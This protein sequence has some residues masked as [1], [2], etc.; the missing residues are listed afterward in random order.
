[1]PDDI[2]SILDNIRKMAPENGRIVFVSGDFNIIHP[3]HQ[4]I[5]NFAASCGDFLVVGINGDN[6]NKKIVPEEL[7]RE[8]IAALSVVNY[9]FILQTSPED[10]IARLKPSVVVKG[11]E[12]R[13]SSNVEQAVVE[14]YG[15]KLLF[16]SGSSVFSSV[17]L[18]RDEFSGHDFSSIHKPADFPQR[19]GFSIGE[20]GDI[21]SRFS[22]LNVVVV[23]D[24]IVDEYIDC[25]TLGMSREDPTLVVT[26][27]LSKQFVGG[28]GIVA[29]H[30]RKLGAKTTYFGI[31]GKDRTARYAKE[32]LQAYDVD[33]HLLADETRPTTLKQRYRAANKTLLRVSHLRQHDIGIDLIT[34]LGERIERALATADLLIFSDFNYGCLPQ[35]LVDRIVELCRK[36]GIPIAADSQ[37]SSQLG[38][39]SRFRGTNLLTPTEHEAR[40]A[41]RD[42]QSGLVV[43][44]ESLRQKS[45]AHH[46][47]VTLAAEGILIHTPH[48]NGGLITD[49]LPAFN[50]SPR[51][52][53]GAGD[54]LFICT[55]MALTTG[56]DIW[57]SAYLGSIAAACQV[58][59]IGN[60]PLT[61]DELITELLL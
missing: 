14:S 43:L 25:D 49:Q 17:D 28:A 39:V 9:A 54:C 24:L 58:S 8:G 21:V 30:A 26:P 46:I 10:F 13:S 47:L 6:L 50:H 15:G 45:D 37:A 1:M 19:H 60:T 44:A 29:A 36:R 33:C 16:S 7:R 34:A 52:V 3:G 51:D 41:M 55:A 56:A 22:S 59:R 48:S 61:V 53:S 32:T 38:D 4:R 11:T 57:K 35:C 40:L 12:H 31:S 42:S 2:D 18:L 23:G 5:I 20:L 27:V